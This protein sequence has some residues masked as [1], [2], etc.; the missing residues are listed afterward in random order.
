MG[1]VAGGSLVEYFNVDSE[2]MKSATMKSVVDGKVV[3]YV[4]N[5]R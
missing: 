3:M 5:S 1:N 4:P 2:T